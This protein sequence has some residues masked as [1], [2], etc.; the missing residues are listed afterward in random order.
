MAEVRLSEVV[1]GLSKALDLTE[2]EHP[3]HAV[4]TCLIGMRLAECIHLPPSQRAV[5]H[6]ALLLK[7]AGCSSN[8]AH[9]AALFGADDRALKRATKVTDWPRLTASARYALHHAAP[10]RRL[11]ERIARLYAVAL[12]GR[13]SARQLV[14]IRCE[15]GAEIAHRLGLAPE[16]ASAIRSLDEHW[17]GGGY[18]EGLRGT[19]IPLLARIAGLAQTVDVFFTRFGVEAAVDVAA[20]RKGRW[21]DPEL[22]QALLTLRYDTRF[23]ADLSSPGESGRLGATEPEEHVVL[24]GEEDLDRIAEAFADII[25]AKSPFTHRHSRGVMR[26]AEAIG[27]AMG[28]APEAL[29]DLRRAA[30]LHDIGKLGVSNVILDKPGPLTDE[31]FAAVKRH[32][33]HTLDILLQVGVFRRWATVAAAHHE[34]MDGRGYHLGIPAGRL[35]LAARLLTVADV[36]DALSAE[37]PYRAALPRERVLSTMGAD[38]GRLLCPDCFAAFLDVHERL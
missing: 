13:R 27:E 6:Y 36:F 9:M 5:L 15:R 28:F 23:W 12:R 20:R 22:V 35:P 18:P 21:F 16:V 11:P 19:A 37:R 38:V 25:D 26:A 1:A 31:E 3:G 8:A 33:R 34:R 30:L 17:D 10:G 14:Q 7:D 2:G 29:R 32:P 24:A 4:R